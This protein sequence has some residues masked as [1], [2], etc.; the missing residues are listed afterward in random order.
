MTENE[1]QLLDLIR[2]RAF[3]RGKFRLSSGGESDH[4][5]DGKMV[6][7]FSDSAYLIGEVLYERTQALNVEAIGGLEVGAVPLATAAVISY[8]LHGKQMEGFW[9]RD[10]VKK[11]GTQKLIEGNLRPGMRVVV[12]D[13]VV[14]RGTSTIK[15]VNAVR[16]LGCEAVAVVCLVDRLAGA[17]EL[18]RQNGLTNF[19]PIFTVRDLGVMVETPSSAG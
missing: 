6:E 15:A 5:I 2:E 11:H 13:D 19:Q 3:K 10:E 8:R 1:R 14:T 4:Y 16:D 9:V 12:L 18:Y 7:V 17:A